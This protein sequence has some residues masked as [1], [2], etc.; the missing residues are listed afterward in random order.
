MLRQEGM[1]DVD[2]EAARIVRDDIA[3]AFHL[4]ALD[5]VFHHLGIL[6]ECRRARFRPG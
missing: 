1:H 5:I 4:V 6:A 2:V 3:V